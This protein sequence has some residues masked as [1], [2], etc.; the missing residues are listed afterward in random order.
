MMQDDLGQLEQQIADCEGEL[1]RNPIKR[2]AGAAA[3]SKFDSI[4][5][6]HE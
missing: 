6:H 2:E 4:H 1:S 5:V 3:R